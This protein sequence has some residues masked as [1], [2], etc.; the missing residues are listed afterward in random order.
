[1][2]VNGID[3][4]SYQSTD[5][6]VTGLAF[7]AI[8]AT[9]GRS[10]VNPKHA[11]QVAYARAHGLVVAHYHFAR[12]GSVG[13]QVAYFLQHA[14]P[15]SG[16]VLALDWE[17]PA[18]SDEWKDAWIN[19]ARA[20]TPGHRVVLYC[21]RDFWLVRDRTGGCGDGLWIA[22]P[23]AP[24]GH[25]RV[26]HPWLI[27]QYSDAG[28]LDRDIANFP[29]LAALRAWAAGTTPSTSH[30]PEADVQLTDTYTTRKSA[31]SPGGQTAT[32]GEWLADGNL[33]AGAAVAAVRILAAQ[34]GALTA[35]VT[36][37]AAAVQKGGGLTAEQTTAAAKAGA[38]AAL[39]ELGHA[40]D[41]ITTTG[42]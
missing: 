14:A 37:L 11:A 15:Q 27:H 23:D 12:P 42:A 20:G 34:V 39:A 36:A 9:E 24:A 30:T 6:D 21:N 25:P 28:G 31:W 40:L 4:A 26:Q 38:D 18:V 19:A 8:K 35:T 33:K 29:S 2:T 13:D 22:D 41:G 7:V 17:D 1:M 10:Y 3:I 16:D 5:Y 32:V